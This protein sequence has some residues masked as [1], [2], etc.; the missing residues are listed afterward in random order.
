MP[1]ASHH[2]GVLDDLH[3]AVAA[4]KGRIEADE[5]LTRLVQE[6]ILSC[7]GF[8]P[9]PLP[10]ADGIGRKTPRFD[11]DKDKSIAELNDQVDFT[12]GAS[13]SLREDRTAP[14]LIV[15]SGRRFTRSPGVI[16]TLPANPA[17]DPGRV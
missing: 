6:S 11:L 14:C 3:R 12:G 2:A 16:G 17:R 9:Q 8:Q 15:S 10:L 13:P 7:G 4:D 5:D 1:S